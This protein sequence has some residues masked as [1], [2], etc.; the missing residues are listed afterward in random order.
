VDLN[1]D[2]HDDILSGSYSRMESSMAGLFQVLWGEDDGT[3][4]KAE[5]LKGTDDEPLIIP[6][7]ESEMTENIC[8]RPTAA[9]INGDEHLDIVTGNFS[10]TFYVFEGKG[11]GKFDPKP[12][13]IMAGKDALRV[14]MHSDPFLVDWDND[15]DLDLLSGS[16]QGGVYISINSG[17]TNEPKF[18]AAI[19]IYPPSKHGYGSQ[20]VMGDRHI[21]GPQA[22][23]RVWADDVNGDGKLDL[24]IGDSVRLQFAAEGLDDDEALEKLEQ[25]QEEM[26]SLSDDF[27]KQL[28][29]SAKETEQESADE[30]VDEADE[31][32]I[33]DESGDEDADA[34]D[35]QELS[36]EAADD[37]SAE[38]E[39]D[40]DSDDNDSAGDV[41]DEDSKSESGAA[42]AQ[43]KMRKLQKDYQKAIQAL[44]DKR[45]KIV[46]QEMTGY[47]WV[48]YQK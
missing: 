14:Q 36:D 38:S 24:L 4:K 25:W 48:L 2:G 33:V 34:Q 20:K 22:A 26:D 29:A 45:E 27:Q 9:D 10:G 41:T 40:S 21:T 19:E 35:A 42:R 44:W 39:S 12:T 47:V 16:A 18:A 28:E 5:P 13:Q 6:A 3:F 30:P 11:K 15:N 32:A 37:Q 7:D 23:T 17:S 43:K 1:G 8:T 46:R 31:P